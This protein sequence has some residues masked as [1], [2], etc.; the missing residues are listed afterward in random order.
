MQLKCRGASVLRLFAVLYTNKNRERR[1]ERTREYEI[2]YACACAVLS[3][4]ILNVR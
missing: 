4:R 1:Q 3:L 2:N